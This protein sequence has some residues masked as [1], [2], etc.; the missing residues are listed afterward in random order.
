MAVDLTAENNRPKMCPAALKLI[1]SKAAD[2]EYIYRLG[3]V[4]ADGRVRCR[5]NQ[6]VKRRRGDPN[7]KSIFLCQRKSLCFFSS[8]MGI[9]SLEM[10]L[11]S[12]YRQTEKIGCEYI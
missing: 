7:V 1:K 6:M 3:S 9:L 2:V 10:W 4:E 12:Q 11:W 5:G 8:L